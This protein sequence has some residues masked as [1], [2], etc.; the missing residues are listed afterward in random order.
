VSPELQTGHLPAD[1]QSG[2]G[3]G[4]PEVT[5]IAASA[6][7]PSVLVPTTVS[8]PADEGVY[9]PDEVPI[10][11]ALPGATAHEPS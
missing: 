9:T 6:D 5:V 3:G 11:P 1:A 8:V 4:P 10:E 7:V 2:N